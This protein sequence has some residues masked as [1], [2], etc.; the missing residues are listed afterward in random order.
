[1]QAIDILLKKIANYKPILRAETPIKA[2]V[3]ILFLRNQENVVRIVLTK[4]AATL[5]T[6]AG[7]YSFPGGM[8]DDS[9]DNLYVTAQRE[10]YEE[11]GIPVDA[12]QFLGQLNDSYS[13]DGNLVRPFVCI[14]DETLFIQLHKIA[15][16]EIDELYYLSLANLEKFTDDEK[17]HAITKRRPSYSFTDGD[18]FI[19]GLTAG[20]L[21]NL[22]EVISG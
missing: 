14:M 19:W 16:A 9:D 3:M 7:H 17:L 12:Y 6:Y 4:R 11:L 5:P 8:Y 15:Y 13:R 2:A 22:L 21:M 18:T 20:I 10:T 1:M